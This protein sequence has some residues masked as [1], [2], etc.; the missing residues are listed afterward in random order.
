MKVLLIETRLSGH[1]RAYLDS[2]ISMSNDETQFY[3][4]IPEQTNVESL[5]NEKC[6]I[7]KFN[8]GFKTYILW[9]KEVNK[10]VNQIHPDIIH[11]VYGD[12]I[13]RY[14]GF[15]FLSLR[16][17]AN[18][19]ITCHQ[20]RHSFLRDFGFKILSK[21]VNSIVLHTDGLM[22]DFRKQGIHNIVHIE[23]PRFGNVYD[24]GA[25]EARSSLGIPV[26][27]VPLVLS[28]GGTRYEKGLDILLQSLSR[29]HEKFYLLIAGN[30]E[31]FKKDFI[32]DHTRT[33][34][35]RVW[36]K[37]SFLSDEEFNCC[38]EAASII[39]LPY[40]SSFDG[41]SGPL[42]DGVAYGKMIIGS[43]HGSL[44]QLIENHHL[45]ATFV[46]EDIDDLSQV[47]KRSLLMAW[48]P[49]DVY[50]AYQ[51]VLDPKRFQRD[52]LELYERK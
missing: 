50:K 20:I 34:S 36:T 27:D 1:H 13:Y 28:L 6:F 47:L 35:E 37:L 19:V 14:M 43:N 16:R 39:A 22:N 41:A 44:G 45:G 31:Y 10:V 12:E 49:D 2:L 48:E 25:S 51:R 52:Y 9:L 11:F 46:C 18:V 8:Q 21:H 17:K 30:E 42:G 40:R 29:V 32:D 7:I 15:G 4:I 38:I 5:T 33:Y 3:A 24:M 26:D 23:Y